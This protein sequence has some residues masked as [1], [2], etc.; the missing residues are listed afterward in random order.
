MREPFVEIQAWESVS[1]MINDAEPLTVD[2]MPQADWHD[3]GQTPK[4]YATNVLGSKVH[5]AKVVRL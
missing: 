4:E 3:L 2:T 1:D 5:Q